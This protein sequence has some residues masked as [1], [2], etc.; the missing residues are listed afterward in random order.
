MVDLKRGGSPA[1]LLV[2]NLAGAGQALAYRD[3]LGS[4][5]RRLEANTAG[6][7]HAVKLACSIIKVGVIVTKR[8]AKREKVEYSPRLL[9]REKR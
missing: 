2:S 9:T 3:S 7:T 1:G 8:S 6:K 4:P 5:A